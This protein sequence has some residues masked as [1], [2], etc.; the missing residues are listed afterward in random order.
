M[1]KLLLILAM[2]F[3]L[4]VHASAAEVEC[5]ALME[6][7]ICVG[8]ARESV[9]KKLPKEYKTAEKISKGRYGPVAERTYAYHGK[10]FML[11]YEQTSAEGLTRLTK[12]VEQ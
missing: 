12:I 1:K 3:F 2:V 11:R 4:P 10:K 5:L 8:E 9:I 7:I 6:D